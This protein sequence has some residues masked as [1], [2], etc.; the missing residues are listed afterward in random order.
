MKLERNSIILKI[1]ISKKL[2]NFPK[3]LK[4]LL[5]KDMNKKMLQKGNQ[6]HPKATIKIPD[7]RQVALEIL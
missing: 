3:K 7:Q 6:Q 5:I 4:K 2:D 1:S